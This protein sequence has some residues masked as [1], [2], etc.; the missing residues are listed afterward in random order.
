[1]SNPNSAKKDAL[2]RLR[3]IEGHVRGIERMVE[4]DAYCIDI[5]KQ[6]KAVQNALERVNSLLLANHLQTCVTTALRSN[7]DAER[8]RVIN[9]IIDVFDATG[10]LGR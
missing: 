4:N 7:D 6:I 1:M 10:K 9:E 5:M 8:E 2:N 3:S